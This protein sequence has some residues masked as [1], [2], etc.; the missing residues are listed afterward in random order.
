ML[1]PNC[2]YLNSGSGKCW[3]CDHQMSAV[4][5]KKV[6]PIAK[7]TPK[8]AKEEKEYLKLREV[9]LTENQKCAVF[10]KKKS[11]E[12]HHVAGRSGVMLLDTKYWL[13][14]SQSGH[15]KIEKEREWAFKMGFS[16]SR[17]TEK[18]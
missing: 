16:I 2:N 3:A 6:Q 13:P 18:K 15:E 9:F 11:T 14:V 12:V 17:L 4:V 1:C 5:E 7:R 10:P 8:R